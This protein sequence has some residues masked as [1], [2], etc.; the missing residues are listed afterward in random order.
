MKR[1]S[2]QFDRDEMYR[3]LR[4]NI[5]FSSVDEE[6]KIVNF[7]STIPNEG[8]STMAINL[9]RVCADQYQK[10]LLIDCDL[11]NSSLHRLLNVKRGA[12]LSNLLSNFKEEDSILE[13]ECVQTITTPTEKTYYF[14]SAGDRVPNPLEVVS[15]KS[16]YTFLQKAKQEFDFIILDC[17]PISLCSDG[18][19]L[20]NLSDGTLYVVSGKEVDKRQ[21]K[22]CMSELTRSGAN[23]IG[24]CLTK[25]ENITKS[26]YYNYGY[27]YGYGSNVGED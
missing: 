14:I 24:L 7:I 20:C 5:E 16:L 4:T 13:S 10:V 1:K 23:I 3:Q 17:P 9:A 27:G 22:T 6:I 26:K 15:S 12:G 25:M 21:A 19:P 11:R 18:T 2:N 8:K